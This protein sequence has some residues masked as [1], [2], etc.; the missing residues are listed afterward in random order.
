M[1]NQSSQEP[2]LK[3]ARSKRG[4]FTGAFS[5]MLRIGGSD[6]PGSSAPESLVSESERVSAH[7]RQQQLKQSKS[8]GTLKKNS[9]PQQSPSPPPPS[10][11]PPQLAKQKLYSPRPPPGPP[12]SVKGSSPT[13]AVASEG[14]VKTSVTSPIVKSTDFHHTVA[15]PPPRRTSIKVQEAWYNKKYLAMMHLGRRDGSMICPLCRKDIPM[16]GA[17]QQE[18]MLRIEKFVK[19]VH[20]ERKWPILAAKMFPRSPGHERWLR[21]IDP[22]KKTLCW[23]RLLSGNE[24]E[25]LRKLLESF[26]TLE[27][28]DIEARLNVLESHYHSGMDT[29]ELALQLAAATA[30]HTR[31][32]DHIAFCR[33][34]TPS[35]L[36]E[37]QPASESFLDPAQDASE[38]KITPEEICRLRQET[39]LGERV[40]WF[41]E[42]VANMRSLNKGEKAAPLT[43]R[44]RRDCILEDASTCFMTIRPQELWRQCKYEF[45]DELAIDAGGV[46][47]EF[48]SL[49]AAQ[50]FDPQLGL[51]EPIRT[52]DGLLSYRINLNSGLANDLHLQYFR[53]LG[54]V[55]AKGMIDGYTVPCHLTRDLYKHLIGEPISLDDL[56]LVD[57]Q[58]GKSMVDVLECSDV[59]ALCLDFTT[60]VWEM[61]VTNQVEL[62]E[63]GANISVTS[64]NVEKYLSLMLRFVMLDRHHLQLSFL[65]KGFEEVVP[66]S[67][68]SVFSAREFEAI[69]SGMDTVDVDDWKTNTEYRG[70]YAK[71]GANHEV[72]DWFWRYVQNLDQDKRGRLLQYCTGSARVPV[73]GF[74]G[75]Q[76]DD[77][78]ALLFSIESVPLTQ[79]L[80]PKAHTC[81]NRLELP[82]YLAED[83]LRKYFDEVLEMGVTGFNLEE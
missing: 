74:K 31:E 5:N 13:H 17:T 36:L 68:V 62:V 78:A 39:P 48:F 33:R 82:L 41:R 16:G 73:Q 10:E 80:Y 32:F 1:G 29:S 19:C 40:S 27:R 60:A 46:A 37:W 55:M 47:R 58:L 6:R 20:C 44:V 28:D 9:G 75:L 23:I 22:E 63:N 7:A 45:V 42:Q 12:P 38:L 54:R 64:D 3:S 24:E 52:Q 26:Q 14:A 53:F 77:G 2:G 67:L 30:W 34:F 76:G 83:D 4:S 8:H 81:F 61:G 56:N 35:G 72:V 51:F 50:V 71:H 15:P 57:P 43:I 11:E 65:L 21:D 69:L 79:S 49:V 18:D 25:R 66:Q 70:K 59:E